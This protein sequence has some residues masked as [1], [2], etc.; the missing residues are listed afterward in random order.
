MQ[1]AEKVCPPHQDV[2]NE[3]ASGAALPELPL[4]PS[5]IVKN[6]FRRQKQCQ[7]MCPTN[8]SNH[9]YR[10]FFLYFNR[11]RPFNLRMCPSYCPF[12]CG[13]GSRGADRRR[14]F[15]AAAP[16]PLRSR[17]GAQIGSKTHSCSSLFKDVA[18]V[19]P[20]NSW[21]G[22]LGVWPRRSCRNARNGRVARLFSWFGSRL[23]HLTPLSLEFS[24]IKRAC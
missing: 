2:W 20:F 17:L 14:L 5:P 23:N 3:G 21:D 11:R 13:G 22:G 15:L 19:A 12:F 16:R 1:P 9:P 6:E 18:R 24:P 8:P 4:P 10:S 7:T